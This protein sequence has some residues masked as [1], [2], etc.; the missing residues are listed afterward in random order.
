MEVT[1][2]VRWVN[3]SEAKVRPGHGARSHSR[4]G[5]LDQK[6]HSRALDGELRRAEVGVWIAPLDCCVRRRG[7]GERRALRRCTHLNRIGTFPTLVAA[8]GVGGRHRV[9]ISRSVDKSRIDN[10]GPARAGQ[11]FDMDR[12]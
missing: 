9:V 5:K 2:S 11:T 3:V 10:A 1:P 12:R 8:A 4:Y 6:S 7:E